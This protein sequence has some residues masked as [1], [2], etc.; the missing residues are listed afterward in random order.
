MLQ[1]YI[2]RLAQIK[3]A[4]RKGNFK[5][6]DKLFP[7]YKKVEILMLAAFDEDLLL[8]GKVLMEEIEQAQKYRK[9]N[10]D[11]MYRAVENKYLD[12]NESLDDLYPNQDWDDET[13]RLMDEYDLD[14]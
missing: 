4:L 7:L 1:P 11:A 5:E 6:G 3:D 8:A 12:E 10:D 13:Q 9:I 2:L 14:F